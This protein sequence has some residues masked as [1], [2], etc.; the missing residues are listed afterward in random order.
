VAKPLGRAL[1]PAT[2]QLHLAQGGGVE[3]I[4]L[5]PLATVDGGNRLQPALGTWC[6]PRAIA[7]CS[8]NTGD[9]RSAGSAS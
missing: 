8:E 9:G 6:W 4:L 5:Q 7:L 1:S 3:R 2:R